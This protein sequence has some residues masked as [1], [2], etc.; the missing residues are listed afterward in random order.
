[1]APEEL[2]SLDAGSVIRLDAR[3]EDA[4]DVYVNGRLLAR[5]EPVIV[6]GRIGVRVREVVA[7]T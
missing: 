7:E 5:G 6:G 3:T 1:M 4:V 2:S